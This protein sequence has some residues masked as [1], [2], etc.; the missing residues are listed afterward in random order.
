M[1]RTISFFLLVS[2]I[3]STLSGT[4]IVYASGSQMNLL[5]IRLERTITLMP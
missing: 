3:I 1:K 2:L 5:K 4:V